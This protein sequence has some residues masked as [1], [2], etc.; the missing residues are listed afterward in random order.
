MSASVGRSAAHSGPR[1]DAGSSARSDSSAPG[2]EVAGPGRDGHGSRQGPGRLP[3]VAAVRPVP[4]AGPRG[5]HSFG[6]SRRAEHHQVSLGRG[7]RPGGSAAGF[8]PAGS[9][10]DGHFSRH[11]GGLIE[12]VP[13][14]PERLQQ[15]AGVSPHPLECVRPELHEDRR[16]VGPALQQPRHPLQDHALG[17]LGVH[18]RRRFAAPDVQPAIDASKHEDD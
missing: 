13:V 15:A 4:Y 12:L 18:L 11:P 5:D 14:G 6:G 8:C 7:Y 10:G 2:R 9:T 3:P 17:P 16:A 1:A